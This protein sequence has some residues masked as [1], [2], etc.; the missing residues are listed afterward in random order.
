MSRMKKDRKHSIMWQ[1]AAFMLLLCFALSLPVHAQQVKLVALT[2]DDG[3]CREITPAMLDVLERYHVKA[4]F[5]VVGKWLPGQDDMVA[6]EVAAGHQVASHTFD[7]VRLTDL[8]D[9]QV[10]HE[11]DAMNAALSQLVE[12]QTQFM[13]R[14][15]M[16]ACDQRVLSLLTV[17]AIH[18]TVDPA[19]GRQI[20]GDQ[21]ARQ[22]I[23]ETKD[24]DIILMHDTTQYNLDAIP[25]V[26]EGLHAKGFEFVTVNELFRLRGVTPQAGQLYRSVVNPDPEGYDESKMEQ[27]WALK[28]IQY[29]YFSGLM[30]GDR[31]GWHPN[32]YISRSLA[33]SLLWYIAGCPSADLSQGSGFQDVAAEAWYAP[34]VTWA[35]SQGFVSGDHFTPY[36]PA[37]REFLYALVARL[38]NLECKTGTPP[39]T[40]PSYGD[41]ARIDAW[42]KP[43]VTQ[44]R[45]M[46]FQSKN[47]IELFRPKDAC[48]R[49]EAAELFHWYM[50]L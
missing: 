13:V 26:I 28:D 12:G 23:D 9:D 1:L 14:P 21:M 5:F 45:E 11:V 7:H 48:T 49:A 2:F 33:V 50:T 18:W 46:G 35:K 31:Y 32:Q 34:A 4:T 41:D 19:A 27:H 42:A 17:P 44:L 37:T 47:D 39:D 15:P 24:G 29:M 40:L 30:N 6:Q 36:S 38:S 20:P 16:G 43:F 10:R 8:T 3:P 22:I 25:A